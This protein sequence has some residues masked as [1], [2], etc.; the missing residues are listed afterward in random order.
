MERSRITLI[1]N[2]QSHF[3]GGVSV[4]C[5]TALR[6]RVKAKDSREHAGTYHKD[7]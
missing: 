2:E 4:L 7:R 3:S 5:F 6:T 1:E